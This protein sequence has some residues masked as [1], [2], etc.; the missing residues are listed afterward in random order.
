MA[1]YSVTFVAIEIDDAEGRHAGVVEKELTLA[2]EGPAELIGFG[3]AGPYAKSGFKSST[4]SSFNGRAIVVLRGTGVKG[5]G[6]LSVTANGLRG[7]S[8]TVRMI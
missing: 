1:T 6:K 8:A 5:R 3:A 7:A 2:M 4:A